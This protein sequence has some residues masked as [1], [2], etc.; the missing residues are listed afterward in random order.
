MANFNVNG[1]GFVDLRNTNLN[2]FDGLTFATSGNTIVTV[3]S[4]QVDEGNPVLA[5]NLTGSGFQDTFEIY[6]AG[7]LTFSAAL[8]SF[9]TWTDG[10]DQILIYDTA[11]SSENITGSDASEVFQ[12]SGGVGSDTVN[13]GAGND[14]L[15]VNYA[16]ETSALSMNGASTI[17]DFSNTSVTF[18]GIDR[19]NVTL[20]SN[21]DNV[22]LRDGAD[23]M[24]G[25][26]GNDTLNSAAGEADIDGGAGNDLWVADFSSDATSKTI[27]LNLAG[28]Q[29]A[30]NGSSYISV[31]R[32]NITGGIGADVLT[33]RTDN[34]ND[35]LNDT[36]NGGA[37]ND[38]LTVGG[39]SDTV[40]GGADNDLL[41]VN[42]ATE[43]SALSMNGA[44][45]ISDFSNTSV[46]F[47]GIDRFNVTLGSN[48]DNVILLGGADTMNGGGGNDTLNSAAGEADID[49]GAGNDLWVADFS[50]DAT[51]KTINL[52]L[53]GLQN[54]GN[55]SSYISVERLN[56]TGGNG[57]DV[58]ATRTDNAND[59]LND[60]LNGGAGNDI[61]TV[62]GGFDTVD[63]GENNDLLIVNYATETSSMSMNG[64][65]TIT[66]FSN[67]SVTFSNIERFDVTLG[68]GND[69]VVLLEGDDTING[70]SGND[71][72]D[73][74]A[75]AAVVNGGAGVD[76]WAAN[77]SALTT[78]VTVN[79]NTALLQNIGNNS[80]LTS[81]EALVVIGGSGN[82]SFLTRSINANENINDSV[83]GGG[84]DDIIRV[85]GGFDTVDGGFGGDDLLIIGYATETSSLSMNG[86]SQLTDFSNTTVSFSNFERFNVTLG[87]GNDS[88]VTLGGADTLNGGD[89]ND[90][91]NSAAGA[92]VINGGSGNDLWIADFSADATVKTIN[93]NLAGIQSAGNGTTYVNVE[94][95]TIT[96][97]AGNDTFTTRTDNTNDGLNDSL[98]G[99]GGNDTLT[100]GGGLDTVDG[101]EG[102]ND[103]LIINYATEL[104]TLNMNG[105]AQQ[106]TDFSNTSVTFTNVERFNVTL[107]SGNDSVVTL[108]GNDTLNGGDGNDRL[109]SA[110]GAAVINGGS[111]IDTWA[112]D[113]SAFTSAFTVDLNT[114][115]LQTIG[116]ASSLT[117]V[118][119]LAVTGG[120]GNDVLLT[121][122][123]LSN[124]GI[125]DVVNGG[126]GDDTIR[127]GGGLDTVDGGTG[128]NDLLI[129]DYATEAS[130]LNMNG[131]SAI[132]DFSNTGVNF[133]NFERFNV[134][135]GSG[136]DSVVTLGGSDTL[137][138]GDGNDSL[139]SAAGA[140]VI[141]GGAGNDLWIADFTGDASVKTINLNL[142]GVQAAGNGTTYVSVERM[143]ISGGA[144]NDILTSRTDNA[145]DGLNDTLNGGGGNDILTVGGGSDVVD[146]GNGTDDVLIIDY[147]TESSN[148]SMNT[149]SAI[150]DFS[151]TTVNFS[152]VER[153]DVRL[154][155]G[156]DNIALGS[157]N[158]TL[159]GG[160]GAD[161]LAGGSGNDTYINP[162][163]DVIVEL[164]AGGTDTVESNVTFS[165]AALAQVENLTLTGAA[166]INAVGN[167]LNNVLTGNAGNNTLDGGAGADTMTGGMGNDIYSVDQAGDVTTELFNQGTDLVSSSVSRTLSANIEN[168]NLSGA[169]NIDGNGNT[170]AN[171]INGNSANNILRG[172]EG[173][174]TLNGN[175]GEDIL[176]GGTSSDALNPGSDAVRDIIRFSAVGDSTGSQRDIVTGMDLTAE[177]VFDFTVIPTSI[178][179]VNAGTLNLATIN[180]DLATA[181]N[182]ALA[183]NGAVLFDP[184]AGDLNV[185]GHSFL[186]VDANG[187]GSYTA[188]QDYVVQLIN[189]TGTLT[190]DDFI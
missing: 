123:T 137:N 50:F 11:G 177:D 146:G 42:Y 109:N 86:A 69:N 63:G 80:S 28:L 25:G 46:T 75:G 119:A 64:P 54:A 141:N 166:S 148:L 98:N 84:G 97:G 134:T 102:D 167:A 14:L 57:A 100:V 159:A 153:F 88:V 62:G 105:A 39:G 128:G 118:E 67:T 34:A 132:S 27:N 58:L 82:D 101:G 184:T 170:S 115:T 116:N 56:I 81:I 22:T 157:G 111:G 161:T 35:G 110:A 3:N 155:Q 53:A 133:S 71:R 92:A 66:D 5:Y 65:A 180:A 30:G 8:F 12:L 83:N 127:V 151:N 140:A 13:G 147:T 17:S 4:N 175:A 18:S 188:G 113:L 173:G 142:S 121:R 150:T 103:L 10:L 174:D 154:G 171:V 124:D 152:N 126:G 78:G 178:A 95:L 94:R 112:A 143:N 36:L 76:T 156:N 139:N 91:L 41:I 55:G 20:G 29:N 51:P 135:L 120:S 9:T 106:L 70:G 190:L 79:L 23:T 107:G 99:G 77:L 169:A 181:V 89:G 16:T 47:S 104:S 60:T 108:D 40:D 138:G 162:L 85:G 187:D 6:V 129:V 149:P 117:S 74:A 90:S 31:E 176:L 164:A 130:N 163:G 158:D 87:S 96:G 145:N 183:I 21:N 32:L 189:P 182:A 15:I 44:A 33:T 72:L 122:S 48:N 125:V 165:L 172:Y 1:S 19:F 136:N 43:T 73:T 131:P 59:G 49:G 160:R 61:L 68:S 168:L 186:V 144:G 24:N 38:I 52:N 114:T 45:T 37:G 185:A 179:T 26:N 7:G 93:L 2:P